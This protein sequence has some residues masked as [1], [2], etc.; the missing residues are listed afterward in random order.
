LLED[1]KELTEY[2]HPIFFDDNEDHSFQ[3]KEN[4]ENSSNS[5]QEKEGPPQDSDIRQLIREE[6]CIEVCEKQKQ[7]M[8]NTILELVEICRQK[9]LLCMHDNA[10]AQDGG[11]HMTMNRYYAWLM[12]SRHSISSLTRVKDQ[13]KS[14]SL[15]PTPFGDSDSLVEETDTLLSHFD[16]S[17][18]EYETNSFDIEEKSSGKKS[19]GS[20]TTHSNF[21]LL[22]YDSFFFDLLIDPFLPADR[23]DF[24]H[25]E[26]A[27]EL[28]HII[29]PS[30]YDCF[31]FDLA[32]NP[33]QFTSVLEKNIFDLSTK[34]FT[35]IELNNSPLLLYDYDSSLSK[36]FFEIDLLVSFPSGNE[37][38]V[39]DPKIIITKGVQFH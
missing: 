1:L 29:Y 2:N 13:V 23:S 25:E 20:T 33:G 31:Y 21:S 6:C 30:K 8:E 27:N 17:S 14:I 16:N 15:L 18:P 24:Y 7:N 35:C 34:D 4:L 19:S 12:I 36:E 37:G 38:V 28:A 32:A 10:K 3:N 5:N 11:D 9:E 39:F 22:E 26:F